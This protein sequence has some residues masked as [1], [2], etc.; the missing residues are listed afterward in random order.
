MRRDSSLLIAVVEDD[1]SLRKALRRLLQASGYG[2]EIYASG[3]EFL[4]TLRIQV[5]DCVVLDVQMTPL[6]GLDVH[7]EMTRRGFC[8]PVV[9]ISAGADEAV[10]TRA[11][12][13][14][15]LA[16]LQKPFAKQALLKLLA[17]L[18]RKS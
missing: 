12:Q 16:Y 18:P 4:T 17:D 5:P 8:P 6:S 7:T 1:P 10:R 2:A 11:L 15:A 14:G 9:F 3:L 13:Q